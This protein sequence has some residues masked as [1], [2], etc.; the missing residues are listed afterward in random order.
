MNLEGRFK[1][2]PTTARPVQ[3]VGAFRPVALR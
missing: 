1:Q 3:Q 2:S